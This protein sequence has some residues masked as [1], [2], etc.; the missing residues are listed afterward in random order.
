MGTAMN[1]RMLALATPLLLPVLL[2]PTVLL[3]TA[4]H[5]DWEPTHWGMSVEQVMH[6][7]PAA[8][9]QPLSDSFNSA[10]SSD[11]HAQSG[12]LYLYTRIDRQNRTYDVRIGFSNDRLK[13]VEF[14][15]VNPTERDCTDAR[16]N[17]QHRF[18]T[19]QS[20]GSGEGGR[21]DSWNGDKESDDHPAP[22]LYVNDAPPSDGHHS[23]TGAAVESHDD[24]DASTGSS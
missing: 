17:L 3:S 13:S 8:A 15:L 16:S 4:A 10:G 14:A 21:Y 11:N 6:V 9:T 1:M 23:D 2:L 12:S 5:A 20:G 19:P 18:G 24:A 7:I 22:V